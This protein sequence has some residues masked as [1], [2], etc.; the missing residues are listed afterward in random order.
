[1]SAPGASGRGS[2]RRRF[3]LQRAGVALRP[4][5]EELGLGEAMA[6]QKIQG[7][8]DHL[9]GKP[10]SLHTFPTAL[11][12]S[13]LFVNVDSPVWLQQTGYLRAEFLA[14][15]EGRGVKALKLRLGRISAVKAGTAAKSPPPGAEPITPEEEAG[16]VEMVSGLHDR[17]L[18]ESIK[19]AARKSIIRKKKFFQP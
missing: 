12:K 11:K 18:R 10:L 16:L 17:E 9:V 19:G 14:K 15:L 3:K 5:L 8:W 2:F 13:N 7:A 4:L 1:M 6:L